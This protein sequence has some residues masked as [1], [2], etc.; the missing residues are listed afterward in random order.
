MLALT[1]GGA[2][3]ICWALFTIGQG[4]YL[5]A[6]G[7]STPAEVVDARQAGRSKSVTVRLASGHETKLW[8]WDGTPRT[9]EK[10]TVVY[11]E[12]RDWARDAESFA[13]M[14]RIWVG[15]GMG[16]WLIVV[17]LVERSW[18]ARQARNGPPDDPGGRVTV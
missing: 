3:L 7:V 12:E 2:L 10:M 13:P 15:L 14:T 18:R 11:L 5:G 1:V 16:I 8:A 17:G 4:L 6:N 9:G